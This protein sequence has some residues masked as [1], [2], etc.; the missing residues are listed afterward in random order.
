MQPDENF[1]LGNLAGQGGPTLPVAGKFDVREWFAEAQIPIVEENFIDLL[2]IS[3]GYRYSNYKTEGI[4]PF[5]QIVAKNEF[6]RPT[7]TRSRVSSLRSRTF[8]SGSPTT[9][10]S[11]PRTSSSFTLRPVLH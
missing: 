7:R 9:A 5:S 8:A 11:G 4:D 2:Q 1:Q 6:Q 3:A 10:R